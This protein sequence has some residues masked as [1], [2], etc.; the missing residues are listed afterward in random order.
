MKMLSAIP[1]MMQVVVGVAG[2]IV[3][4]S[5]L[6]AQVIPPAVKGEEITVKGEVV[7]LWCYIRNG[8]HRQGHKNCSTKCANQGNPIGFLDEEKGQ[9]YILVGKTDYQ[10]THEVRDELIKKMNEAVTVVGTVVKKD[11]TQ[12]LYVKSLE[13]KEF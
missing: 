8:D 9:L 6:L 11:G 3:V 13:G 12:M 4:A 10:V 5:V 7:D 1:R 2:V